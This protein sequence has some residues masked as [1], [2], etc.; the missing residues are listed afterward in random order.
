MPKI[1]LYQHA[2]FNTRPGD[3][4]GWSQTYNQATPD[5]GTSADAASSCVIE[6]GVWVL[7]AG[8]DYNDEQQY[9]F[10]PKAVAVLGRG[11]YKMPKDMGLENDTL[12]SFR[13]LPE[14]GIC[15]FEHPNYRGM[16]IHVVDEHVDFREID[17]NDKVSSAI[18]LSGVWD[19]YK[20]TH[21]KGDVWTL[22]HGQYRNPTAGGFPA[23]TIS[24][25]RRNAAAHGSLSVV[26]STAGSGSPSQAKVQND[27]VVE[28][29]LDASDSMNTGKIGN[30]SRLKVAKDAMR[31]VVETVLP[32]GLQIALRAFGLDDGCSKKLVMELAPLDKSAMLGKIQ[33]I[34]A[35][36]GTDIAGSL[37][38]VKDDLAGV[39]APK[40]VILVT[41]GDHNCTE[42]GTVEDAIDNLRGAGFDVRINFVGFAIGDA[43]LKAKFESWA[44]KGGGA[45]IDAPD[46]DKLIDAIRRALSIPFQVKNASGTKVADGFVDDAAIELLAGEY[47]VVL[48]PDSGNSSEHDV[49]VNAGTTATFT[50]VR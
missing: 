31:E 17:A 7:Y 32:D 29:V 26:S 36:G 1:T 13:P 44:S 49:T 41:D 16:M 30:E 15:L 27:T 48:N 37:L 38:A 34:K 20:H 18:V 40:L 14:E 24:S 8:K 28:L 33:D 19:L 43:A 42:S 47:K 3:E 4:S 45:Y 35:K 9:R 39:T 10:D 50:A 22:S 5:L 11:R 46:R 12:H 25:V 23:D 21:F 2:D 6:E